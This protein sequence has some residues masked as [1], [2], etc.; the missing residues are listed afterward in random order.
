MK[1]DILLAR[2]MLLATAAAASTPDPAAQPSPVVPRTSR[3]LLEAAL[4]AMQLREY[5]IPA[6]A[7]HLA[8]RH[9]DQYL[10]MELLVERLVQRGHAEFVDHTLGLT[11]E[12]ED[13]AARIR[14]R[15]APRIAQ[16]AATET[17]RR[18]QMLAPSLRNE[19][20]RLLCRSQRRAAAST[21]DLANP[22][23]RPGCD[24]N[25]A[26]PSRIGNRLHYRTG[27]ITTMDGTEV[28]PARRLADYRPSRN[29]HDQRMVYPEK[30][31]AR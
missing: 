12:G 30:L 19:D 17:E 26:L 6:L 25:L 5:T 4:L 28:Q 3:V 9:P 2:D 8:E 23:M 14:E 20:P 13:A 24:A 29:G 27:R 15:P 22:P 18:L 7:E 10:N 11:E 16:T 31:F 1:R 21:A